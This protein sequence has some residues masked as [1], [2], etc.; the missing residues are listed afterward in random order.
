MFLPSGRHSPVRGT[1][2]ALVL[3]L[4]SALVFI[5]AP[6]S[7]AL[8]QSPPAKVFNPDISAIGNFLAIAGHNTVD[9]QPSFSMRESE[10]GL[11]AVVDPY[12]R[13]D[14]FISFG[15]DPGQETCS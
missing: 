2:A 7:G 12:A 5:F 4:A 3:A 1:A 11:Q 15:T 13:A 9:N 8:A 6:L 14:F 10:V